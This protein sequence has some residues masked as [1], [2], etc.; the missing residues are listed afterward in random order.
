MELL[1]GTATL[2]GAL[3]PL[4]RDHMEQTRTSFRPVEIRGRAKSDRKDDRRLHVRRLPVAADWRRSN[5]EAF[6]QHQSRW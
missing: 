1:V 2:L 5:P 4:Y 6:Q 3:L